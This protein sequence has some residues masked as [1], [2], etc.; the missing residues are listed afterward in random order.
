MEQTTHQQQAKNTYVTPDETF[1][2]FIMQAYYDRVYRLTESSIASQAYGDLINVSSDLEEAKLSASFLGI[3]NFGDNDEFII[4]EDLMDSKKSIIDKQANN[5]VKKLIRKLN[6]NPDKTF[7]GIMFLAG[8]GL[9]K[10]GR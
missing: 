8:H 5:F 3:D 7:F 4:N 9:I 6:E 1:A 10:D 2:A